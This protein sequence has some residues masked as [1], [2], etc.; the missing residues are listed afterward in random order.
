MS[1]LLILGAV[2]GYGKGQGMSKKLQPPIY[3]SAMTLDAYRDGACHNRVSKRGE[4]CWKHKS[5]QEK[6]KLPENSEPDPSKVGGEN[7]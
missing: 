5:M 4:L 7:G 6:K 2:H 1:Y 3:C